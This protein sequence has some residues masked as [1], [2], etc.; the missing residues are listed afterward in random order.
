M[1]Y[2]NL[3]LKPNEGLSPEQ[4]EEIDR[5]YRAYPRSQDG[6]FVAEHLAEWLG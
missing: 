5:V 4:T 3:Y 2:I 6:A 1:C